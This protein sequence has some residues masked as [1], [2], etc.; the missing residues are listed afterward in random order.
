MLFHMTATKIPRIIPTR[1]WA[2]DLLSRRQNAH[3][4]LLILNLCRQSEKRKSPQEK[5]ASLVQLDGELY[6]RA[7]RVAPKRA[8][9]TMSA[10]PAALVFNMV[11]NV[12]TKVHRS[13]QCTSL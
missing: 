13:S 4:L 9:A 6:K 10:R 3:T 12:S 1:T 11:L 7:K 8:N 5:A 2:T